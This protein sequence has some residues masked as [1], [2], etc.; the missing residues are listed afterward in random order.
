[1]VKRIP[2]LKSVFER[3]QLT[4]QEL[5]EIVSAN[6]SLRGMMF[7]YVS[8]YK[9]R[10]LWFSDP[11]FQG[12]TKEDDHDRTKKGDLWFTYKGV[13]ISVEVKSLQTH[14]VKGGGLADVYTGDFQCDASD[15]R[16]VKLPNG[17]Q[18]ETTCL[19]VGEFDVLAVCLFEFGHKWRFAFAKNWDLP[20]PG[21]RSKYTQEQKNHLLA[22][23]IKISWPLQPPFRTDLFQLLD[24]IVAEKQAG[25][26]ER[27]LEGVE[28]KS[29]K[30]SPE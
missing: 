22:G 4:P 19:L 9:L 15:R 5:D 27:A 17:E 6:P 16:K 3:W 23:S 29:P 21:L 12:V 13:R 18:L 24:E 26:P 7:G 8:E 10:K 1:V 2:R 20:H 14:S 25:I 30:N 28:I 11:I